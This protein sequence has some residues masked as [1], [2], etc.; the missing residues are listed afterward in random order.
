MKIIIIGCGRVGSRIAIQLSKEGHEVSVIDRNPLA[1]DKLQ[2]DFD[3]SMIIGTGIDEDIL[4]NAGIIG[5]DSVIS[6]TKGDNTNIMVGQIAKFLFQVPHVIVRIVDPKSKKF[7]EEE[8]GLTCYCPT[9]T[10]SL[11]YLE[12]LKGER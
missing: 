11:H 7:Y 1:F 5:A 8:V 2:G 9:E 3:G 6:V 12:M 10:S 4:M